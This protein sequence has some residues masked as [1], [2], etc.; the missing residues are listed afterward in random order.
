MYDLRYGGNSQTILSAGKYI[1]GTN[2]I[3]VNNE[4]TQTRQVYEKAKDMCVL[5]IRNQL[6]E[7]KFTD[8]TPFSNASTTVDQTK[9]ECN[10]MITNLTALHTIL[11]NALNTPTSLAGV[12]NTPPSTMLKDDKG[13]KV[14]PMLGDLLDL[15]VIEASPYIQN[16]S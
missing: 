6:P 11:D 5:A 1:N 10:A 15:P 9:P 7:A 8:I 12:I 2:I 4:V 14:V 16:S 3:N 13:L